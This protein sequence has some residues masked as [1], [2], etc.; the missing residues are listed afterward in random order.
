MSA[1]RTGMNAEASECVIARLDDA[2]EAIVR[3]ERL[4]LRKWW[5]LR[6]RMD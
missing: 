2:A 1:S 5:Q 4:E 6:L 3:L